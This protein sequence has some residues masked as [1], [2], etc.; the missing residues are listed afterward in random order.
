MADT[1]WIRCADEL[2][3]KNRCILFVL[4]A[5]SHRTAVVYGFRVSRRLYYAI[6]M[7]DG[8]NWSAGYVSYWMRIPE[9]PSE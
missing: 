8:E 7:D 4:N 1:G 9:P 3:E 2:P 6:D 5:P